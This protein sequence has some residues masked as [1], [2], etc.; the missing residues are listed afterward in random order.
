MLGRGSLSLAGM[1]AREPIFRFGLRNAI[2][3]VISPRVIGGYVNP[4]TETERRRHRKRS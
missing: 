1:C 3:E 2:F 4:A